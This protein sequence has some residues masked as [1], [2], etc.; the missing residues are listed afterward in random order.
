MNGPLCQ[1]LAVALGQSV[2]LWNA[3]TGSIDHL[4]T[5]QG[6]NDFV[7]RYMCPSMRLERV[8]CFDFTVDVVP[9]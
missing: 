9:Y 2:Y 8:I 4:L 7:T 3:T 1:V 5:L 6:P